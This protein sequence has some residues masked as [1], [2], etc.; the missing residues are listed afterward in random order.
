MG[1]KIQIFL[2]LFSIAVWYNYFMKLCLIV[3]K[4]NDKDFAFCALL[5]AASL[6][7][8]LVVVWSL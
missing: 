8:L 5:S 6:I 7:S 3:E 1:L 4:I 2:T